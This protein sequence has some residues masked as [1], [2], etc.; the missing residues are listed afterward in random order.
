MMAAPGVGFAHATPPV[1]WVIG[2]LAE[3][4]KLIGISKGGKPSGRSC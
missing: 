4:A 3:A 1:E 2:P